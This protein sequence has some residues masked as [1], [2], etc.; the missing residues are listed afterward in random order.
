MNLVDIKPGQW[1]LAFHEP[2]G[3]HQNTMADHLAMFV[4]RGGGWDS[5]R[6][7]EILHVYHVVKVGPKTYQIDDDLTANSQAYANSRQH[8]YLVI[9][10][11][12]RR[13]DMLE[14]RD[15]FFAIGEGT[16]N[17]IEA[18]MHRRVQKFA[19]REEA[20]ALKKIH[21]C[22]PHIFGGEQ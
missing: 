11:S 1:V 12:D 22:L 13:Q 15:K 3:P 19:E 14:L 6:P 18:E 21:Q 4:H 20:K 16:S 5:H 10:A 17:R 9:A 7:S 8:R 2:Y